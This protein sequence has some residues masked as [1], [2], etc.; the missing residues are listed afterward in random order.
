MA[1]LGQLAVLGLYNNQLNGAVPDI[2]ASISQ[3]QD[4]DL[5][6]N[7]LTGSIPPSLGTLSQVQYLDLHNNQ[8]NGTF[9]DIF[10]GLSQ[11]QY[12]DVD[13]N[14]LTGSIPPSLGTLP[15]LWNLDLHNNQLTGEVPDLSMIA[16]AAY[17]D[18]S[19]NC[20]DFSPGSLSLAD[21]AL[22]NGAGIYPIYVPQTP[23]C[24]PTPTPSLQGVTQGNN[25]INFT[26]NA[27]AGLIYQIQSTTNLSANNWTNDGGQI[28]ATNLTVSAQD[29]TTNEPQKFYR[30]IELP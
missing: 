7:L 17:V 26:W 20:L 23:D 2:F 11:L 25:A 18:L 16:S 3:L 27:L 21:L 28:T 22:M 13:G 4:L 19:V 15:N 9:S 12:L 14:L 29:V 10:A 5:D 24:N 30:I 6:G 1:S 8:F